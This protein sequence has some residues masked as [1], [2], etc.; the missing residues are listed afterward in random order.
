MAVSGWGCVPSLLLDLEVMK[1][2]VTSFKTSCACT[3]ILHVPNP[4]A[5]HCQP[6]CPP[7][8]SGHSQASLSQFLVKLLLLSPGFCF[9]QDFVCAIQESVSPVLCKFW[10]LY[11]GV[12]GNLLQESLCHTHLCC[13]QSPCPFSRPLLTRT[14]SGNTQTLKEWSKSLWGPLVAQGIL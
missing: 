2:T 12:N 14:S 3:A 8:I 5:D 7:E 6:T 13:T 1:N 11:S 4:A 9:S 10:W